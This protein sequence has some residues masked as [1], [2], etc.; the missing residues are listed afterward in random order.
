MKTKLLVIYLS[1]LTTQVF[2]TDYN[3]LTGTNIVCERYTLNYWQDIF[4][5][6]FISSNKYEMIYYKIDG[7]KSSRQ[8]Y[9][10]TKNPRYRANERHVTLPSEYYLISENNHR[11]QFPF[12]TINRETLE[13]GYD[14]KCMVFQGT[15]KEMYD[16]GKR[17]GKQ[18]LLTRKEKR[19][20]KG[21]N[22][23]KKNKF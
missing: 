16:K 10:H 21:R 18:S 7:N 5:I 22:K 19:Q 8:I 13:T 14:D 3:D 4:T 15:R 12:M 2:A 20:Q 23:E 6:S 11:F 1:L 9:T 17:C